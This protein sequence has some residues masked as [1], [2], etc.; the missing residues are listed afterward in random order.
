LV[1]TVRSILCR[2]RGPCGQGTPGRRQQAL[3][4]GTRGLLDSSALV[5]LAVREPESVALLR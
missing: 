1:D 4:D 5:K 3:A 2:A